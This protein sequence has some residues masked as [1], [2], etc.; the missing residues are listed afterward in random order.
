VGSLFRVP[1]PAASVCPHSF[2]AT[3][4]TTLHV[5]EQCGQPD[6]CPA[7]YISHGR[8]GTMLGNDVARDFEEVAVIFLGVGSHGELTNGSLIHIF[9]PVIQM[10]CLRI[11][12]D[13]PHHT[14]PSNQRERR[15]HNP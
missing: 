15:R 11:W 1:P 13:D 6:V 12:I 3:L 4:R 14:A 9:G 5:S 2:A 8:I 10:L 7:G